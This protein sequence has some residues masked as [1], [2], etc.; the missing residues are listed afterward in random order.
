MHTYTEYI[1][2]FLYPPLMCFCV[3]WTDRQMLSLSYVELL[4]ISVLLTLFSCGHVVVFLPAIILIN[5]TNM[6]T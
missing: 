1:D 5:Y 2:S 4:T 3:I 6:H